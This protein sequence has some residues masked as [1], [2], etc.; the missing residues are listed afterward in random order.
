MRRIEELWNRVIE[1]PFASMENL[2]LDVV[3]QAYDEGA[4]VIPGP[5]S[6]PP[7]Q[8]T[9]RSADQ[10]FQRGMTVP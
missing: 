6:L 3:A 4:P 5:M 1:S 10:Q 8:G 7:E 2:S 9:L